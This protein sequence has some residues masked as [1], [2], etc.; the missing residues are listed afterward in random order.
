MRSLILGG[1][2]FVGGYLAPYLL[3]CGDE[4]A[5]TKLANESLLNPSLEGIKSYE[6]DI[7]NIDSIKNILH[8]YSPEVIYHL[9]A[10]SSVALS[11]KNP[12]LTLDIN[13]KGTANLLEAI[14][15]VCPKVRLLIIGSSEEYGATFYEK[16]SPIKEDD[17]LAPANIYALTKAT[18]ESLAKIYI[19]A[20][21]LNISLTRS[22][23]HIGAY[24]QPIF[25]I[26][27]F[28][29]Q[30][31]DI[32]AGRSESVIKVGNLQVYRDFTH[33]TDVVRA[34]R[35]IAEKGAVGEVYNVGSGKR[36]LLADILEKLISLS[37][38]NIQVEVDSARLRPN[39]IES[40]VADISK[41]ERLGYSPKVSIDEAL[42]DVLSYY[43]NQN[44]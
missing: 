21:G 18:Q 6:L 26:A 5:I 20:Y 36:F 10:Q 17:P 22:F 25:V 40:V 4:V 42:E 41:L 43:R 8:D 37:N 13:I 29:K 1:A 33:V 34:Y 7:L 3:K 23:N 30:V 14:R 19:S 32:E 31:A 16:S 9:V 39:D 38:T 44:K 24:Q 27:S 2:G 15:E 11:W 12:Q 28:A 35:L